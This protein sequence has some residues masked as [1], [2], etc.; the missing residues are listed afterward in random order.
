MTQTRRSWETWSW[1][2]KFEGFWTDKNENFQTISSNPQRLSIPRTW[3]ETLSIYGIPHKY[4]NV[5]YH[6]SPSTVS[7]LLSEMD[8]LRKLHN[9]LPLP[10]K[11]SVV[12]PTIGFAFN[13]D[14]NHFLK[15]PS[16]LGPFKA[17]GCVRKE[18]VSLTMKHSHHIFKGGNLLSSYQ[19]EKERF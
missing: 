14:S 19:S 2:K 3:W 13:F 15:T 1:R 5:I 9:Q 18:F 4:K 7:C 10:L 11:T 8:F 6:T 17:G 16:L 12:V